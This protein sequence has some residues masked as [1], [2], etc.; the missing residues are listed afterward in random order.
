MS[1]LDRGERND[2][3]FWLSY[4]DFLINFDGVD[5]CKAHKEW[6]SQ[7]LPCAVRVGGYPCFRMTLLEHTW[8][9]LTA[10]QRSKR[11]RYRTAE[12]R[13][14]WYQSIGL[15]VFE[16]VAGQMQSLPVGFMAC[17]PRRDSP[18]ME[19]ELQPGSYCV[20]PFTLPSPP[21]RGGNLNPQSFILRLFSS[22]HVVMEE[23]PEAAPDSGAAAI[24]AALK[25]CAFSGQKR[26]PG[27]CGLHSEIS[28]SASPAANP[29][30]VVDLTAPAEPEGEVCIPRPGP[31]LPPVYCQQ[32]DPLLTRRE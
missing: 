26:T 32:R 13:Q 1:L 20:L 7:S 29:V 22:H 25:E 16:E 9:Y 12:D 24:A 2:G 10:I 3:T 19:L 5:I 8:L 4:H 11:G 17:S 6:Y 18:P 28:I 14:Y 31:R 21:K 15:V 30:E 23:F 27:Y